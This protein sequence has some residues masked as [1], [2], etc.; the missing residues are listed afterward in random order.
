MASF[1]SELKNELARIFDDEKVNE[2][3]E[4][5]ALL[6]LGAIKTGRRMEFF[7]SNAAVARKVVQLIKRL[8]PQIVTEVSV[9][10]IKNLRKINRYCVKIYENDNSAS[11]FQKVKQNKMPITYK[12]QMAY[13]RGAFLS[14]GT[15][16]RPQAQYHAEIVAASKSMSFFIQ[17]VMNNLELPAKIFKRKDQYVV[18]LKNFDLIIEFLYLIKA[19]SAIEQFEIARNIKEVRQQVNRIMTCEEANINKA[20][21]AA[22]NQIEDIKQIIKSGLKLK[23][24]L[25]QTAKMRLEN[26]ELSMPELAAKMYISTSGLKFRMRRLHEIAQ[27]VNA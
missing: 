8:Y 15:I 12:S 24:H 17:D 19:E 4:L 5:T 26:P 21:N 2:K 10:R 9:V 18:Y 13:L 3:A 16:N 20:V 22:Q 7:N 14:S 6:K 27:T 1:A 23:E 25:K 11:L